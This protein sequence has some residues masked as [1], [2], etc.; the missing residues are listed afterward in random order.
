LYVAQKVLTVFQDDVDGTKASE[1]ISFGLDG[2]AYQIDLS[3]RNAAKLRKSF[4]P[5]AS[6]ARRTGGRRIRTAPAA[7][8]AV[9]TRRPA[10]SP[11]QL[12][13]TPVDSATVRAWAAANK[14]EVS[15]RGRI[16]AAVIAQFRAAGN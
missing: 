14:I 8:T 2:V 1:T 11:A 16:P 15:T 12:T 13:D 10:P 6:A 7:T 9:R 3:T 5:F 4:E